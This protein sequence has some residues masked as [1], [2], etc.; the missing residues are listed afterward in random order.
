MKFEEI[1]EL[2]RNQYINR[3]ICCGLIHKIIS[4]RN[5]FPEYETELFLECQCGE[6]V[7][8]ILPVN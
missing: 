2:S 3:C 5:E 4:K 6:Y 7:G 8:F 1:E